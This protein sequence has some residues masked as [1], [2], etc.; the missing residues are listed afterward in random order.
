VLVSTGTGLTAT[1]SLT[2]TYSIANVP[3]GSYTLTATKTGYTFASQSVAV[4]G[5]DQSGVDFTGTAVFSISG[6]ITRNGSALA[7]VTL[8]AGGKTTTSAAD[9]TYTLSGLVAGSYTV[10]PSKSGYTFTPGSQSVTIASS[11]ISSINF[12]AN[13]FD[14]QFNGSKTGWTAV[15]G[16][17]TNSSTYLLSPNFTVAG[18]ASIAYATAY[19]KLDYSAKVMRT[20]CAS[21]LTSLYIRGSGTGVTSGGWTSGYQFSITRDGKYSVVKTV[22]SKATTLKVLSASA[23]INK[24]SAWNVLRV[25]ASGTSLKFY[26]NGNL[27]WSGTDTAIAT[28][29]V[30]IG[31]VSNGTG[32]A[33]RLSVDYATL[34]VP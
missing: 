28:G 14:S 12:A 15:K 1:T 24:L 7:G 31:M 25:V 3:N 26:V 10:T 30:G 11:N 8:S 33:N 19:P 22:A 4:S 2:G 34:A 20:G 17:W 32:G 27:V 13:L 16:V 21:C 5:A 9:G 23:Y 6:T 29:K 18:V